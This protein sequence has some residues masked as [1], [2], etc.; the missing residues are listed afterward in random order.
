MRI[1]KESE[2]T[3]HFKFLKNYIDKSIEDGSFPDSLNEVNVTPI[4]KKITPLI[5]PIMD[6][7]WSNYGPIILQ[8]HIKGL[9]IISLQILLKDP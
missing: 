9:F 3:F 8:K 2:F 5:S 7:L 4:F 6:Q 1:L